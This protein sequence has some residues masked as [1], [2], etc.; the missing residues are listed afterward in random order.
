MADTDD[1]RFSFTKREITLIVDALEA[2]IDWSFDASE[3]ADANILVWRL[4]RGDRGADL[5]G[6]AHG[7]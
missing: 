4:R 3:A 2:A 5:L 7:P 1:R 6:A